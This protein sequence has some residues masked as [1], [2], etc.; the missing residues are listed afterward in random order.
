MI[1][2][3]QQFFNTQIQ[4]RTGSGPQDSQ[5]AL[6]LA[7]AALLIEVS[8]ADFAVDDA[9]QQA[10]ARA[11]QNLFGLSRQ[12]TDELI[13]LAEE[14]A[15]QSVSLYQFTELVDKQFPAEQKIQIVEMMW[16]V[17]FA[18]RD[19]DMHEEHL[20]SKVADLL[21]VPRAAY[22]RARHVAEGE[23]NIDPASK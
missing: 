9:E 21:H 18:D 7:T 11:V 16:R 17:V 13:A 1:K 22:L 3:I 15:K 10:V 5:Q 4:A 8:R 12:Q 14:E 23:V 19:N 2:R 20:V 6:Q